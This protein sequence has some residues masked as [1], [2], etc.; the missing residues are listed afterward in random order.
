VTTSLSRVNNKTF[1]FQS[2]ENLDSGILGDG[3]YVVCHT[4]TNF[5]EKH[6]SVIFRVELTDGVDQS[7]NSE[8]RF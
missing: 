4:P 8:V 6:T 7:L 5:A 1:G 2:G 3:P